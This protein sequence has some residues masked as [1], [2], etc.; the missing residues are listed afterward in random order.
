MIPKIG[1]RWIG[2]KTIFQIVGENCNYILVRTIPYINLNG[3]DWYYKWRFA[4]PD[5]YPN[6]EH[7]LYLK[8]QD[9]PNA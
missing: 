3:S 7:F 4:K 1:Q 2:C 8:N 9:V 5:Q 6:E